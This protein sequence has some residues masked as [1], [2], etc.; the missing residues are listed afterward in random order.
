MPFNTILGMPMLTT[1][2][3][4][5]F[6]SLGTIWGDS[7]L[8]DATQRNSKYADAH[9][10]KGLMLSVL[11]RHQEAAAAYGEVIRINPEDARAHYSKGLALYES[12]GS[13]RYE[14]ASGTFW[15]GDSISIQGMP[16]LITI[17]VLRFMHQRDMMRH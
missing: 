9:F 14:E 15:R 7:C 8:W 3:V 13:G 11:G 6:L 12:T 1:I 16:M 4:S 2:R 10:N 17:K 5:C